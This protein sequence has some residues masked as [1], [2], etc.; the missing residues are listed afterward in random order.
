MSSHSA[1]NWLSTISA[2]AARNRAAASSRT[3]LPSGSARAARR[4]A[5]RVAGVVRV[6]GRARMAVGEFG[7]DGLTQE[8]RAGGARQRHG[9]GVEARA[10]AGVDRRAVAGRHVGGVEDVLDAERHALQ[11]ALTKARVA[12]A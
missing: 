5:R 1:G 11:E 4:A 10:A 7:S 9:A 8:D 3:A 2:P 6:G 12:F